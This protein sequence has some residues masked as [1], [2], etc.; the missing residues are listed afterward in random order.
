MS[1]EE[2]GTTNQVLAQRVARLEGAL[3]WGGVK[4]PVSQ[5]QLLWAFAVGGVG[6]FLSYIGLGL[7]N[8][9]YQITFS[10]LT[11]GICYHREVY[12][13]PKTA[14]DYSLVIL[15]ACNLTLLCKLLIGAGI[16]HP[17][18]FILL[19]QLDSARPEEIGKWYDVMPQLS[20]SWEPS[21]AAL[22]SIDL[23]I[24]QT[25]LLLVTAIGAL[26][27]FQLFSSLTAFLLIIVSIPALAGFNWDYVV[28][29]MIAVGVSM[30]LQLSRR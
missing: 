28:P 27:E 6:L 26:F 2:L 1:G 22:W 18:F 4:T 10:L 7:P 21:S 24:V 15:N 20:L 9:Y 11:I 25:F 17:L 12:Q 14:L 19:P 8:H 29:A 3:G 5:K 13:P 30:Y 23:T 16:R